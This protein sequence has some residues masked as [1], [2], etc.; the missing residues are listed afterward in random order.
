M[1]R[2]LVEAPQTRQRQCAHSS[3]LA[4]AG[5]YTTPCTSYPIYTTTTSTKAHGM[6]HSVPFTPATLDS[7]LYRLSRTNNAKSV[8]KSVSRL[9]VSLR[10]STVLDQLET[11][12]LHASDLTSIFD[13]Q[14]IEHFGNPEPSGPLTGSQARVLIFYVPL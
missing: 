1:P 14:N 13:D 10:S 5:A 8:L 3:A 2:R 4:T 6:K 12:C 7:L 9:F 11:G